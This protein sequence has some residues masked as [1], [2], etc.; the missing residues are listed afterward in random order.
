M[1]TNY[2]QRFT[3]KL[4]NQANS[5]ILKHEGENILYDEGCQESQDKRRPLSII[6]VFLLDCGVTTIIVKS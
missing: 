5:Y 1:D 2:R 3:D 6:E 4:K